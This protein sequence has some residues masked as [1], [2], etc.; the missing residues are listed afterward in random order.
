MAGFAFWGCKGGQFDADTLDRSC[1]DGGLAAGRGLGA[2]TGASEI[3]RGPMTCWYYG[4]STGGAITFSVAWNGCNSVTSWSGQFNTNTGN[5][6]ALWYLTLA[7]APA[8]NGINAG[9]DTFVPQASK[10]KK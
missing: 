9:S 4:G 6:Q 7:A 1:G 2:G 8:W 10:V 5:F 3:Y